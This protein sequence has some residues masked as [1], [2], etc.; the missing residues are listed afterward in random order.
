MAS[1]T[2]T[3]YPRFERKV[4]KDSELEERYQIG[5]KEREFVYKSARGDRRR[6][7]LL[8]LLKT[9]QFLGR[10]VAISKIPWQIQQYLLEQFELPTH[11]APIEETETNKKSFHRYRQAVRQFQGLRSWS[12]GGEALVT[13]AVEKAAYAMSDPSDLVN[14]ALETL[15]A[16][17]YKLPA[18][19]TLDRLTGHIR[20]RIDEKLYLQMTTGLAESLR[21]TLNA[22]LEVREDEWKSDFTRIKEYPRGNSLKNMR[23][24]ADRLDWLCSVIQPA[25]FIKEVAHTKIRQFAAQVQ[26]MELG[27]MK[28]ISRDE[29]RYALLLCF[30]HEG[31]VKTRDELINMFLRRMRSTHNRARDKMQAFHDKHRS[32]E[33]QMLAAFAQV[34]ECAAQPG[35]DAQLGKQVRQVLNEH[36]GVEMLQQQYRQ[37]SAYHNRNYLPLLWPVHRQHRAAIFRL[38][39]LLEIEAATQDDELLQAW[40]FI[41][42]HR[43]ARRDYLPCDINLDFLSQRWETYV[44]THHEGE[45]VLKRRELEVCVLSHLADAIRSNDLFVKGSQE[46]S[47]Y[48][49]QLL[50]WEECEKR[51]PEFCLALNLPPTAEAFVKE[52]QKKLRSAAQ[53]TDNQFPKNTD[54]SI[55][56]QGNAHLKRSKSAP[57]PEYLDSF[58]QNIRRRM[59]DRD[60][61]DI[62]KNVQ[63]WTNYTR[64][65]TPPSGTETKM[66][67]AVTRYIYTVFGY[68]CNLGA[69]QTAKHI[70]S[71]ITLRILK[72]INDQHISIEKLEAALQDVVNEYAGLDLPFVWGSGERAIADGTHISLLEN[73]FIG[74]RHIRY[75]GY[76]GIAYHHISDTYIALFCNFIA[77]GVWEA[78]Y[79]LDALFQNTSKLQPDTV[80]ADTQGQTEPVFG[81]AHLLGIKLMPRMRNWDDV[82]FY[83]AGKED[84]YEHI[85]SLFSDVINWKLIQT[86]WKDMMQVV[87]SIQAGKVLPSMLLKKLGTNSRKN[88]LYKAFRELGRVVRTIFLLEFISNKEFRLTIQAETTK[89]ESFH[90]FHHWVTFGGHTITSGDPVEQTKRN[91]YIDLVANIVMLH[92]VIDLTQVLHDMAKSGEEVTLELAKYLSPYLNSQIRRFG[93][94]DLDMNNLPGPLKLPQLA[95]ILEP[96]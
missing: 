60:L 85:E 90:A 65:F 48:R 28:D 36:G 4:L 81:L 41:N 33:E 76:G 75:E 49:Q 96:I 77:C 58:Q 69:A 13:E 80:H 30:I 62:L 5:E 47:D 2:R 89:I 35:R 45:V 84:I 15:I 54:L 11:T 92:N 46:H 7:T 59:P 71:D 63:H 9:Y 18:F 61:L 12:E 26:Q 21:Q 37:V 40:N 88:K 68:G 52:L 31:Q 42:E 25:S 38:L 83:R 67:D 74:E 39:N 34:V 23:E 20:Q 91:K 27:D 16:H 1:I 14:I 3:A 17:R 94:Y 56:D 57:K 66:S 53:R 22:L 78:V 86:H 43:Y 24:W 70:Q 50:G 87:L 32:I 82:K 72:R 95:A 51:L 8:L 55:D 73:N 29:K 44:Q 64:H 93:K 79:I 6:F 19:S 10:T